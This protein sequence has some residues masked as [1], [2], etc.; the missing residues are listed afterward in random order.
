MEGN[1]MNYE[2]ESLTGKEA[3]E[4]YQI[5]RAKNILRIMDLKMDLK[6]L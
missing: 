3:R 5:D 1:W 6:I 2:T 4:Q